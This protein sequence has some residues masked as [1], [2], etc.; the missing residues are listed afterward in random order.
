MEEW[1]S[2]IAALIL[3]PEPAPTHD[4][5]VPLADKIVR[6]YDSRPWNKTN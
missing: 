3:E 5:H 6:K 2:K 1:L 4:T